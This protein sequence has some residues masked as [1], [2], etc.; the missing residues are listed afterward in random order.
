MIKSLSDIKSI[1][2]L[3]KGDYIDRSK[4][5]TKVHEKESCPICAKCG[6]YDPNKPCIVC[7]ENMKHWM[8]ETGGLSP[9]LIT[10]FLR[11]G[12]SRLS[13]THATGLDSHQFAN[14]KICFSKGRPFDP[15]YYTPVKK[16]V[17]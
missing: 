12:Y 8:K 15:S 3:P 10:I 2:D 13:F 4:Y 6:N 16:P 17:R 9:E 14:L 7:V 11:K 1:K 5:R